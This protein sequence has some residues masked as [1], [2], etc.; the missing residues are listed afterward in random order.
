MVNAQDPF[1]E[2]FQN[3]PIENPTTKNEKMAA[4]PLLYFC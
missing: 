3:F 4:I 1:G 2:G